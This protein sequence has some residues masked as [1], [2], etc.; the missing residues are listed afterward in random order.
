[1]NTHVDKTLKPI[2]GTEKSNQSPAR[3]EPESTF[4]FTDNRPE[5][6]VQKKLHEIT[7]EFTN[8]NQ[9]AQLLSIANNSSTKSVRFQRRVISPMQGKVK[10]NTNDNSGMAI[11]SNVI[12]K[13]LDRAKLG[14]V[15][16]SLGLNDEAVKVVE[17]PLDPEVKGGTKFNEPA[18]KD[19][20]DG[21]NASESN[22]TMASAAQTPDS[23]DKPAKDI[24]EGAG[25]ASYIESVKI[26]F[27]KEG[28]ADYERVLRHEVGHFKQDM[29]G[30]TAVTVNQKLLEYHNIIK[31]ENLGEVD[32][33]VFY[34]D[35]STS[36][37]SG[38]IKNIAEADKKENKLKSYESIGRGQ[39][40]RLE[41]SIIGSNKENDIKMF[42]EIKT[43]LKAWEDKDKSIEGR[44]SVA[45]FKKNIAS[46]VSFK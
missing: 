37:W 39:F 14:K 11:V 46:E 33:R 9:A 20:T 2:T 43:A 21:L 35:D 24:I 8:S 26:A 6:L 36:S 41:K 31:H 27:L 23:V 3:S 15:K 22:H 12:Q 44:L 28:I 1:M 32:A 16:T 38:V 29:E 13:K 5:T 10:V 45:R 18:Y 4:Q 17:V 34:V 30:Y 7:N 42:G 19:S 40:D 25:G